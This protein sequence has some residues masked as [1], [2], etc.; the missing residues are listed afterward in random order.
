M[1]PEAWVV[2]FKPEVIG[3][4]PRI[5]PNR[6]SSSP[7]ANGRHRALAR[8]TAMLCLSLE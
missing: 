6:L 2:T 1:G 5:D 3:M 4:S 8:G 7:P